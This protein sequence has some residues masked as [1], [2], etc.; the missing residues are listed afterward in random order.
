MKLF[1]K[2]FFYRL[3]IP[4]YF[5]RDALVECRMVMI[6]IYGFFLQRVKLNKIKKQNH[7]KLNFGCGETYYTDWVNVDSFF[8]KHVD[9]VLDLRRPL[10]FSNETIEYCYSEHFLEHLYPD[11]GL[12][13]LEEVW[14]V[15]KPGGVYRI[16]VPAG[17]RFVEKYLANDAVF[18][19]L[20]F[21]WEER[22]MDAIYHILNWGGE[23]KNIF[24]YAHLEY[25][26]KKVGFSHIR[27]SDVNRSAIPVLNIDKAIPQ[28]VAESLYVEL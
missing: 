25:L 23:H 4:T 12:K 17:I 26:G 10:P 20:A 22:P 18:F 8:S 16:V 11:E 21:P 15:L 9:L 28:R 2:K 5:L 6:R 7:I 3:G 24:D 1:F 19:K 13:H 27:E 14:R